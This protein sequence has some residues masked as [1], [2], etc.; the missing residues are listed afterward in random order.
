MRTVDV[1]YRS[2]GDFEGIS[3]CVKAL[4]DIT[5]WAI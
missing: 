5:R 2:L 4:K 3:A 1:G